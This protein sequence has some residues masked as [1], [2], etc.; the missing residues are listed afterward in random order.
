LDGGYGARVVTE[1]VDG[2]D[3]IV[4]GSQAVLQTFECFRT[5]CHF[6]PVE[7]LESL[8]GVAEALRAEAE[9]VKSLVAGTGGHRCAAGLK[10]V[11][12]ECG[13]AG[14]DLPGTVGWAGGG[15]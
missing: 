4:D 15:A 12:G 8:Q 10:K 2:G 11:R 3:A 7:S 9:A 6:T 1:K 14:G 13:Q 5:A